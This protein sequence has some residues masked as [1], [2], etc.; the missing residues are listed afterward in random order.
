MSYERQGT[1]FDPG[2]SG[3]ELQ[4][5]KTASAEA[6]DDL[7]TEDGPS[8]TPSPELDQGAPQ[9]ESHPMHPSR[10]PPAARPVRQG[11]NH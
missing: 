6:T 5:R 1:G 11:G 10:L 3:Y 4:G 7:S 8:T 9:V 2:A